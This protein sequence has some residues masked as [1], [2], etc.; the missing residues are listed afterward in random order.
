MA[1]ALETPI[2]SEKCNKTNVKTT[3]FKYLQEYTNDNEK[4]F[5]RVLKAVEDIR[6]DIRNNKNDIT[7]L[8]QKEILQSQRSSEVSKAS[9]DSI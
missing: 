5:N 7:H 2:D 8:L 9:V 1:W 6:H 3:C 4:K